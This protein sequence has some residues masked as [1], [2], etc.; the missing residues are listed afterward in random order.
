MPV[1]EALACGCPVVASRCAA[2]REVLGEAA[3]YVDPHSTVSIAAGLRRISRDEQ[4]R[5]RL[6]DLG[7]RRASE[8]TWQEHA[9]AM[10]Q[11]YR[12]CL[13]TPKALA[14]GG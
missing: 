4:G 9:R 7:L 5:G 14:S 2:L 6:I 11:V 13:E 12:E 3:E 8:F 1:G 10:V